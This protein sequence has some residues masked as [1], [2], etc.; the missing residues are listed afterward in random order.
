MQFLLKLFK[1]LNSAQS[2][3]QATLAIS[4]GMIMGLT[5]LSGILTVVILLLAFV[6]NIHLGLFFVSSALFAGVGYLFDPLFEQVGFALLASGSLESLWTALY[7]NGLMRL[8]YFNNTLVLGSTVV[9]LVLAL[10]L[11]F[12]LGWVINHYREALAGVLEKYPRLGLFGILKAS[13]TKDPLFRWWGAGVFIGAGVLVAAVLLMLVDPLVKAALEKGGSAVL[14]RDVRIGSVNTDFGEGA[15][16]IERIE[17]AGEKEGVDAVS[18]ERVGFD[19]ALNALLFNRVH[20]ESVAVEGV[21][22]D[23]A[24]T[25]KKS[26]AKP[27]A[28]TASGA[29]A[30]GAGGKSDMAL[31]AFELPDPKALL[32]KSGLKSQ[33][34]YDDA[35]S[36]IEQIKA[37][38]EKVY[39]TEFSA[40]ALDAYNKE[41]A[42]I[43]ALSS[44]KDP[45][46]LLALKEKVSA[47]TKKINDRKK[48]VASLQDEFK[49]DQKRIEV[50]YADMKKAPMS[51]YDSL[52]S[53]YSL[54]GDGAMNMVGMLF[55]DKVGEYVAAAKRYYAMAEP[56]LKS[57]KKPDE[58]PP[59]RGEGR[60]MKYPLRVPSPDL[61]IAKI[62]IDGTLKAQSFNG[63]V[64]DISDNQKAL[65]RALTFDVSSDGEQVK[66]LKISGA[67]NRLGD[68]VKDSVVFE[69]EKLKMDALSLSSLQ[70]SGSDV[71]LG[72]SVVLLDGSALS[73]KSRALFSNAKM[74]MDAL[75]GKTAQLVGDVLGSIS[76][77]R[78]DVSLG[79]TLDAPE[80][81]VSSDLD[82]KLSG[83]MKEAV[84]KQA[85]AYQKE[86]KGMLDARMK[87]QLG[88]LEGSAG[89]IPDIN[90]LAGDQTK[91]LGDLGSSAGGLTS[92]GGGLKGLLPF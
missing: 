28:K 52:K 76:A 79:G 29:S 81:A 70:V 57:E 84:G 13:Q 85:A 33:K 38:W 56:Y 32:A 25:L 36:E 1:V 58:T 31:P 69:V 22:F 44:S 87:E 14:E 54:D 46:Q 26:V 75:E 88:S 74:S 62:A 91:A 83:A 27:A 16:T 72:G 18:M 55:G 4:L 61:W 7:N 89:G 40:D 8:T 30:A 78:T 12:V 3:W 35:L 73:G 39:T 82:R 34:I 51:D 45:Q 86:L 23:T 19:I 66:G 21:G 2:P 48:R 42:Q 37:K 65:G 5:P 59:P 71:A 6:L 47:F 43:K 49:N 41:L 77:F 15:V 63:S 64:R 67:D 80:V 10:P 92:G 68:S 24:A 90:A 9:A 17:V 50:L 11:Y 60:W 53:A 20:I